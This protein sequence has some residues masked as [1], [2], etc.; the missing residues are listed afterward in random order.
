MAKNRQD[1]AP[2]PEWV[3][4]YRQALSREN[5]AERA[6]VRPSTV[7]HHLSVARAANADL[8][9]AHI[10]SA[11]RRPAGTTGLKRIRQGSRW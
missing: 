4:M 2:N 6:G 5:I 9:T 3:K 7:S 10:E 1:A 11:N 8:R